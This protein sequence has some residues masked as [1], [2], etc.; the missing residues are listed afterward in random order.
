MNRTSVFL[1]SIVILFLVSVKS[2]AFILAIPVAVHTIRH[3]FSAIDSVRT[4]IVQYEVHDDDSV[5]VDDDRIQNFVREAAGS[6][7]GII[8]VP[9]TAFYRY[10]PWEYNGVTMLELAATYDSLKSIFS[11]LA[12]ELDICLVIGTREPHTSSRVY[13]TALFFGP[14]G[15]LLGKHHKTVPSSA[16]MNWTT[17]GTQAA[18]FDT[19]YGRVGMLICKDLKSGSWYKAYN[20]DNIDLF[21]L[22]AGDDNGISFSKFDNTCAE[23]HCHGI[24]CNQITGHGSGAGN[25]AFGYPDGTVD[26]LGGYEKIFYRYLSLSSGT[27]GRIKMISQFRENNLLKVW[28]NPFG[29]SLNIQMGGKSGRSK[30]EITDSRGC[31]HAILNI[32]P[33][34]ASVHNLKWNPDRPA[35]GTYIIKA[36]I[37]GQVYMKKSIYLGSAK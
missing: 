5:G 26:F 37:D 7:A 35:Q 14:D 22:I 9:E 21:I 29:K 4:A 20:D 30:I 27:T 33:Q 31:L 1:L 19:P 23:A 15:N 18:A 6:G 34:V 28:P 10:S 17:A 3:V 32:Y 2:G 11:M 24:L 36:E 12:D 13:N 16:E 8:I 25:S